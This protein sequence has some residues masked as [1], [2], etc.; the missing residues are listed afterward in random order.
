MELR[1]TDDQEVLLQASARLI[2]AEYPMDRVRAALGLADDGGPG[3]RRRSADLGWY[4]LFVPEETGGGSVSGNSVVDAALIAYQRGAALQPGSFVA[5]NVVA[6]AIASVGRGEQVESVLPDLVAGQAGATWA[7]TGLGTSGDPAAGVRAT[8]DG[9]SWILEGTKVMVPDADSCPTM[10]VTASGASGPIQFLLPA[11]TTGVSI[12]RQRSLDLTRSWCRIDFEAARI[13]DALRLGPE[14][15]G[16]VLERQLQL[17]C[18][19]TVSESVG[20][21]DRDFSMALEYSKDRTAFGRPVGSFQAVKHLLADTS[22]MLET[23]KALALD[24]ARAVGAETPGADALVSAAKAYIGDC[25]I[26]LAQNCFQVFGGIGYTW[27]H[28]QHLYLRRLTTDAAL[29][30]DPAWHRERL[31]RLAGI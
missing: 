16:E 30:G 21:M 20:A 31:C 17:A 11:E 9:S 3:Y 23:S 24:A 2:E 5:T 14:N 4:S 8:P 19:L 7:V 25:G 26:D 15:G 10:L 22:L 29:Y 27:E 28:D 6:M 1:P 12:R 13:P 18:V